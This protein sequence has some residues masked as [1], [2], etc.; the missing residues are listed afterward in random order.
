MNHLSARESVLMKKALIKFRGDSSPQLIASGDLL[1][2]GRC[3]RGRFI[4]FDVDARGEE[5]KK[6]K[7][8]VDDGV[9]DAI[10]SLRVE[11]RKPNM[12]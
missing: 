11:Q 2:F 8:P 4:T 6:V 12:A 9:N 1:R 7:V 3:L 10:A 5:R